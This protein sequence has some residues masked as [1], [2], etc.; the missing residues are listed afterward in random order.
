MFFSTGSGKCIKIPISCPIYPNPVSLLQNTFNGTYSLRSLFKLFLVRKNKKHGLKPCRLEFLAC[1]ILLLPFSSLIFAQKSSIRAIAAKP[2][3]ILIVADYMGYADIQPFGHTEINTPSLNLLASEGIRY[4]NFYAAAP[5]CSPSRAAML[6]GMY[7]EKTGLTHNIPKNDIG[8]TPQFPTIA[9]K[10]KNAGY[11]TGLIGKWHLG[12]T[13]ESSPEANGFQTF[14]GFR[15]WGIDYYTHRNISNTEGLFYNSNPVEVN[16]YSTDIFTDS[17][18]A[19]IHRNQR[20]SFFLCLFYNAALPPMQPPGN[21]NDIRD[22]SNWNGSTRQDYVAVVERMDQGIG[23]VLAQLDKDELSKNTIV[24]FT[25]DHQGKDVVNHGEFSNGFGTLWEGGIRVPLI[26]RYPQLKRHNVTDIRLSV[27]M[28]LAYTLL[29][30]SGIPTG[31]N[32]DGINL[33]SKRTD[34]GRSIFW[35]WNLNGNVQSAVRKGKWKYLNNNGKELL[36]DLEKDP[37]EHKNTGN[38]NPQILN[39]LKQ[40]FQHWKGASKQQ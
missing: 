1:S 37:E 10:L 27:N 2:N 39:G 4:T 30:V 14:F 23:K 38:S 33:F 40:E 8:L 21:P 15:D 12:F 11:A 36:F 31:E 35:N 9:T 17:A 3:I 20:K 13:G 22:S 5:V 26:I 6:T 34:P 19:F 29:T 18:I 24:I 7:P 32:L 25:Y 28:D 16:G